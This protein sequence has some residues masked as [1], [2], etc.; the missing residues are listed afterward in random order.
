MTDMDSEIKEL[1]LSMKKVQDLR[2]VILISISH[3]NKRQSL[4]RKYLFH[5]SS[6]DKADHLLL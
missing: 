5:S 1:L 3:S 4:L 6:P 2:I